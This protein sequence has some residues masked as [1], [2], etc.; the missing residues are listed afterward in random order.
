MIPIKIESPLDVARFSPADKLVAEALL[1]EATALGRKLERLGML[2]GQMSPDGQEEF[3][4][5]F[6]ASS[7]QF[8]KRIQL[9]A[10]GELYPS[11]ATKTGRAAQYLAKLPIED[12]RRY[13]TELIPV[14]ITDE[15]GRQ[16]VLNMDVEDMSGHLLAQVFAGSGDRRRIRDIAEQ[17]AWVADQVRKRQATEER[18]AGAVRI[19]RARWI[20]E[21]GKVYPT[22]A[23]VEKGFTRSDLGRMIADLR[24]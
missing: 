13:E 7:R 5:A 19:E 17:R 11:L 9:V 4:R 6:P 21:R 14:A 15:R 23:G 18:E 24:S 8:W 3:I 16:D 1:K 22:P 10:R 20:V 12:Q 2:F